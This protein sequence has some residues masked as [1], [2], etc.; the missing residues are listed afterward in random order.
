MRYG[1]QHKRR[2]FLC[3]VVIII[4]QEYY[5]CEAQQQG[6]AKIRTLGSSAPS[7]KVGDVSKANT[8]APVSTSGSSS[9]GNVGRSDYS[10]VGK[11]FIEGDTGNVGIGSSDVFNS[12]KPPERKLEVDGDVRI[13]GG[14]LFHQDFEQSVHVPEGEKKSS[15][16]RVSLLNGH[17]AMIEKQ[18]I[19]SSP[20]VGNDIEASLQLEVIDGSVIHC[21]TFL[22][23][24]LQTDNSRFESTGR[25]IAMNRTQFFVTL[26]DGNFQYQKVLNDGNNEDWVPSTVPFDIRVN[27]YPTKSARDSAPRSFVVVFSYLPMQEDVFMQE[28]TLSVV[29]SCRGSGILKLS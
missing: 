18:L 24:I 12:K 26:V 6:P 7:G 8:A 23:G 4:T 20:S 21:D 14:L 29:A 5:R 16:M 11:L 17:Y 9:L 3:A 19:F 2:A 10:A 27:Y 25:K 1:S 28:Q 22:S 15:T 13:S